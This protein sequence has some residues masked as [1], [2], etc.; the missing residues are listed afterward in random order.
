MSLSGFADP[1]PARRIGINIW[2]RLKREITE[3]AMSRIEGNEGAKSWGRSNQ[4]RNT[5]CRGDGEMYAIT[6]S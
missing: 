4:D 3:Y 1:M 5:E 2:D 6:E